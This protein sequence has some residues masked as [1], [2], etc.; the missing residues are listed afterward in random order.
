MKRYMGLTVGI[1]LFMTVFLGMLSLI[2]ENVDAGTSKSGV[3]LAPGETWNVSGSPYWIEGDI[4]VE[5]GAILTIEPGV[6]V[7][8]NGYYSIFVDGELDAQ[9]MP[10]Q[11]IVITSNQS[12][13][14]PEDWNRIQID[15]QG[16]AEISYCD[17]SYGNFSINL[18]GADGINITYNDISYSNYYG[19]RLYAATYN[20]ILYN[21]ISMANWTGIYVQQSSRY[22][23]LKF[24]NVSSNPGAGIMLASS[25]D[26]NT[27][28]NNN[29]SF[30]MI[31][32]L[33][34]TDASFNT[35]ANNTLYGNNQ[36]GIYFQSQSDENLIVNNTITF[37]NSTGIGLT[38]SRQNNLTLNNASS[39]GG[40]GISLSS[41][42]NNNEVLE[43]TVYD[44]T[45]S[46]IRLLFSSADN[47]VK[48]N[49]ALAND[50]FGIS[51][52]ALDNTVIGNSVSENSNSGIYLSSA[53]GNDIL[54]NIVTGNGGGIRVASSSDNNLVSDNE[55]FSNSGTGI[56]VS[57]SPDNTVTNNNIS[58]NTN[59]GISVTTASDGNNVT[60][61]D[62]T[63]SGGYGVEISQSKD[64]NVTGNTILNSSNYGIALSSTAILN[65]IFDNNIQSNDGGISITWW[66]ESN[67]FYMNNISQ[68][69]SYG[70]YLSSASL[71]LISTNNI[72]SSSLN[73]IHL[74]Q[75]S[76]NNTI[77][78]NN[79]YSNNEN[80]TFV[81]VSENN[82]V[83]N[84]NITSNNYGVAL[85][86]SLYNNITN[87][88]INNNNHGLFLFLFSNNNTIEN[89]SI[90][91]NSQN[92][93]YISDS[94]NNTFLNNDV[95]NNGYGFYLDPGSLNNSIFHN[96]IIGNTEQ[97]FDSA[98]VNNSWH[99]LGIL[100]GNF[101]SDY[102]GLDDGSG[103]GKHAISGD[104][105]GDTLIPHPTSD[106]DLY[107]L[108]D[109]VDVDPPE[110][111]N[112]LPMDGMTVG[113]NM[114]IIGA[115]YSDPSG[116]NVTSVVLIV[117]GIDQTQNATVAASG[118]TFSPAIPL[119]DGN[120][121]VFL[122]VRDDSVNKNPASVMWS[123]FVDATPP[124]TILTVSSPKYT[125]GLT[126]YVTSSTTFTLSA[127]DGTG[128]GVDS[129]WH[130]VGTGGSWTTYTGS[131]TITSPGSHIIYFNSTDNMGNVEITK[132]L[133]I[134]VDDT[135]P[136]TTIGIGSPSLDLD[137]N[138]YVSTTSTINFTSTDSGCGVSSTWYK[139]DSSGS[140]LP[141]IGP[142][143]LLGLDGLHT[144]FFYS[145]DNLAN[146]EPV[147][148]ETVFVDSNSPLTTITVSNPKY[149]NDPVYVK[150]TTQFNLTAVDT[151][152]VESIWYKIDVGGIWTQYTGD[153]SVALNGSRT[154]YYNSTDLLGNI[155]PTKTLDI[156]VDD[157]APVSNIGIDG[158]QFDKMGI[159]YVTPQT[160]LSFSSDDGSGSG[161]M[162]IEYRINWGSWNSYHSPFWL[163][164]SGLW[165][166]EFNAT[167]NLGNPEG[168]QIQNLYVDNNA[169]DTV[170]TISG[171]AVMSTGVMFVNSETEFSFVS[172]D[173]VNGAG[174]NI[175]YY[176]IGL[177][178][179]QTNQ[180]FNL[181]GETE[182]YNMIG[183]YSVDEL[184]N[185][186]VA[187]YFFL[188]LDDSDPI[189]DAG[190][191]IVVDKNKSI[192]LNGLASWDNG[193]IDNWTWTFMDGA[194][195]ITLYGDKVMY[196]FQDSGIYTVTLTVLDVMGHTDSDSLTVT[197]TD[198]L[199]EDDDGLLDSWETDNFGDLSEDAPG[200]P[201][202][203]GFTNIQ[204]FYLG[205]DPMVDDDLD[206]D[207]DNLPDYWEMD[208]FGDLDEIATGDPDNDGLTN[209]QEY[210]LGSDPLF[211]ND[212]DHDDDGLPDYWEMDNFGDLDED[213]VDD[214]DGD[215]YT[216]IQE[217][218]LGLDPN[219]DDNEDH[220][221]DG[222]PDV[223]E[224]EKFGDL[225]E[226]AQGDPDGDGS[227]NI[228]EFYLG[229]DPLVSGII[230][231]D[232]DD[233][234]LLDSWEMD[235]FGDLNETASG[236][237][238]ND[239]SINIQEYYLVTDPLVNENPDSDNDGLL[240]SWEIDNFEDLDET[241]GSD[242]DF[243][244]LTNIEEFH[245][246]SD[247]NVPQP[248]DPVGEEETPLPWW[249]GWIVAII[250]LVLFL[251]ILAARKRPTVPEEEVPKEP[252]SEDLE[253]PEE[254]MPQ[255]KEEGPEDLT[256][257]LEDNE[258]REGQ[259]QNPDD[260]KDEVKKEDQEGTM[261]ELD[262]DTKKEEQGVTPEG[263]EA[264]EKKE[265]QGG[266]VG[267]PD[268][269]LKEEGKDTED[270]DQ[271]ESI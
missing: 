97:A 52:G 166:I 86:S 55:V 171:Q 22:N 205:T 46:G 235:K 87:N 152:G 66:S 27:I 40:D 137:G 115:N 179:W 3:I 268:E 130:K 162:T 156:F 77:S 139:I 111:I 7:R 67:E 1:M 76:N 83:H 263:M 224:I 229:T 254:G 165:N 2:P 170:V 48:N 85:D 57:Q 258:K 238:D 132:T 184:G 214:P 129:I 167:D 140:W 158:P 226:V 198:D 175:T 105:I 233:D 159:M 13:P 143:E 267:E 185:T 37:G 163:M 260:V 239:G 262:E 38:F 62:I 237:P 253:G 65:K 98:P 231:L 93:T 64:N 243:D 49:T 151:S 31:N 113:D 134:Y 177:G 206:H 88:R 146:T 230:D 247:P 14:S 228:Q 249:L 183:Y 154:V 246:G 203:D 209:I 251:L 102:L 51:I 10:G 207:D 212:P 241:G 153:F 213:S 138:I 191:D 150:S 12:N 264:D 157:E 168:T 135:P 120:H 221:S 39:N 136:S 107:P 193:E 6:E 9:G 73:A 248:K 195:S 125:P 121:D 199:D 194:S 50:F 242:T 99:H 90:S 127:D 250:I 222:L 216:N 56:A 124:T 5:N 174:V 11:R 148:S 187:Q 100:E 220:D 122:E 59:H 178:P 4:S 68:S 144:I 145:E 30:N 164:G 28:S 161:I 128:S 45:Q 188:F 169:P 257:E 123:F 259:G 72:T 236:D 109:T 201:D 108:M 80:G 19:I 110:I 23:Q 114:S 41:S 176:Q 131:F 18:N 42:S 197:V 35:I 117:D 218:H 244:G 63:S 91:T 95:S 34:L 58:G 82:T 94:Q 147:Q 118:V 261:E 217:Y 32:G 89:N 240:D 54:E 112:L 255:D 21:N 270:T 61:N 225:D 256:G 266:T 53:S 141:Y 44:N 265:E 84:N 182:G 103:G 96:N 116:I 75:S 210:H 106:Y 104:G 8:F 126:T 60:F 172:D 43:N 196:T 200:D 74:T 181:S 149:G 219:E 180:P 133:D 33:R 252:V 202:G 17:I 71:N 25:T 245:I 101:W 227:I 189:A 234:G 186:E 36:S 69:T 79:I 211:D 26:Y 204:E 232:S 173:T 155:E 119:S 142:F 92:G 271:K 160:L 15:N 20:N 208:N 16:H 269:K 47:T 223:W 70:M 24:N 215:G 190:S 81:A 78:E 192:L 29:L